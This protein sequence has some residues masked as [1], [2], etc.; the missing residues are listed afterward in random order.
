MGSTWAERGPLLLLL[1]LLL[2]RLLLLLL[3]MVL[4]AFQKPHWEPMVVESVQ[5][6]QMGTNGF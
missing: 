2:L 6:T 1:L 3:P 4:K 5:K